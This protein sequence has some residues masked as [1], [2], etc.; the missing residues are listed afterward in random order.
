MKGLL[1]PLPCISTAFCIHNRPISSRPAPLSLFVC[2]VDE[3]SDQA[4]AAL[5]T[6]VKQ[7]TGRAV[8]LHGLVREGSSQLY[9]CDEQHSP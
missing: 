7:L 2:A 5:V 3:A 1:P 9:I 4:G 8:E 6:A